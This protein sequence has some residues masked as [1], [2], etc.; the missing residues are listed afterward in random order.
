MCTLT[1]FK[2]TII[3]DLYIVCHVLNVSF[4]VNTFCMSNVATVRC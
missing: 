3:Y 4:S 2:D 1:N